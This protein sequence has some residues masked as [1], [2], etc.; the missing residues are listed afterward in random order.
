MQSSSDVFNEVVQNLEKHQESL[1]IKKL[2]FYI[3]KKYWENNIS[4]LNGLQFADLIEELM[5]IKPNSEQL[6]FSVYKLVKT[7]NRP[8]VY[9]SVAKII[10]E[11]MSRLYEI[12][13]SSLEEEE[14]MEILAGQIESTQPINKSSDLLIDRVVANLAIHREKERIKKLIFAVCKNR[15]ENNTTTIDHYRLKDLI[16]EIRQENPQKHQLRQAFARI[17]NNIDKSNLYI[18]ITN[19]IIDQLEMLYDTEVEYEEKEKQEQT[20]IFA[21][22]IVHLD[23]PLDSPQ[24]QEPYRASPAISMVEFNEVRE[25]PTYLNLAAPAAPGPPLKEYDPFEVR[26]EI[27]Q[28]TNTLRAKILLFSILFHPWDQSGQDWLTLRSYTLEDLVELLV[29]SGKSIQ[30][31]ETQLYSAA[32]NQPDEDA[33]LQTASVIVQSVQNIL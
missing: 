19:F 29:Q 32:K 3:C 2:I 6:T 23:R 1:R 11:Q 13:L 25:I 26:L 5:S 12:Q 10:V 9:A 33:N 15:W 14:G 17:V 16:L 27:M 8:G 31:I 30:E 20:E 22:E 24:Q 28:Y 21:G 7:L 4:I 18:A